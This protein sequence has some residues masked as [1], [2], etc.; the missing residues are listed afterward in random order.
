MGTKDQLVLRTYLLRHNRVDDIVARE[1]N[2]LKDLIKPRHACAAR[3]TVVVLCVCMSVRA[4]TSTSSICE[5]KAR[6]QQI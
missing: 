3:V 4:L 6:Y 2:Q 5:A 1:E